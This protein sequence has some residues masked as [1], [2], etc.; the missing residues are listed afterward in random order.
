MLTLV[1]SSTF[2]GYS[3]SAA[4]CM[5][6]NPEHIVSFSPQWYY[7]DFRN[8]PG[9]TLDS[10]TRSSPPPIPLPAK[11]LLWEHHDLWSGCLLVAND[12]L[13][14]NPLI[15]SYIFQEAHYIFYNHISLLF[16][17]QMLFCTLLGPQAHTWFSSSLPGF[18]R[19]VHLCQLFQYS[20]MQ[21]NF[22]LYN[23]LP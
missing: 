17:F 14:N 12:C 8:L 3:F 19:A 21:V 15:R 7:E 11:G 16:P 5:N 20:A 9:M 13:T 4:I 23:S 18:V 2:C 10:M 1:N 22:I 6:H